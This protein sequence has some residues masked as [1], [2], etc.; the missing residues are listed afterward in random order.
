MTTSDDPVQSP[1]L[2][3]GFY[4]ALALLVTG[5]AAFASM[6]YQF[7]RSPDAAFHAYLAAYAY[8]L[9][10]VL[11]CMAFTMISHAANATWPVAVRRLPEA[12]GAAMPLLALLFL[13]VLFGL[14]ALYPWAH[15]A[16]YEGATRELL[17]HRRA[18]MN[19]IGFAARAVVYLSWWSVLSV[20]LRRWSL[21]MDRGQDSERCSR[22][23][24][25]LSYAGLVLV[26]LT[27]GFAAYE[28]FMALSPQFASTMYAAIWIAM[29]L[30]A[31]V[32]ATI[33]LVALAARSTRLPINE[34]HASALG[35][36]LLAF[37]VFLGYTAFFQFL[38]VWIANRPQEAVWYLERPRAVAW[39]LIG[40][41]LTLPFLALLSYR[42]KRKLSTLAPI[43]LWC[44]LSLYVHINWLIVPEGRSASLA[45]DLLALLAVLCPTF[46]Y[47]LLR[48]RGL[49]LA[50][51]SDPRYPA[52]L[53]YVSN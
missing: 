18:Y 20:L 23:L 37:L 43:A 47:A 33:L 16:D 48:Q 52:S 32:A 50:A 3:L 22:R 21:A 4:L 40:G 11:G 25:R 42:W 31:G 53:H 35:R 2:R 15:A 45:L 46:A 30:H 34:S 51:A 41:E 36:L 6:I 5:V 1:V 39:F 14:R 12:L 8:A 24:R 38:L 28:W 10:I 26:G 44:L 29:C 27:A 19:P 17:E 49:P 13:P 7:V 9:S